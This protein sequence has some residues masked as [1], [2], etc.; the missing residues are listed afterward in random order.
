MVA[1][2]KDE[3][4]TTTMVLGGRT[5]TTSDRPCGGSER[6][7][8]RGEAVVKQGERERA[9]EAVTC[10]SAV[11]R[12]ISPLVLRPTEVRSMQVIGHG[13]DIQAH[14]SH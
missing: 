4:Y 10:V 5:R 3:K 13:L 14:S 2:V 1:T 8:M 12:E 9:G 6:G 7:R 11:A